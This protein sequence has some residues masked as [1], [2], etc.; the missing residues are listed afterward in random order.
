MIY[1]SYCLTQHLG[2]PGVHTLHSSS[3]PALIIVKKC[4]VFKQNET[5]IAYIAFC[6][7]ISDLHL[8]LQL[9]GYLNAKHLNLNGPITL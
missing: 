1:L 5:Y 2:H 8:I 7:L 9:F 3:Q 6:K 4:S